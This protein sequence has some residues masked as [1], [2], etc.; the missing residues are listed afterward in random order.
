[1]SFYVAAYDTEAV[2]PWWEKGERS[3]R[4]N[5]FSYTPERIDEFL[6]GVRSVAEAH[7]QRE[8]PASFFLVAK[9]LKLAGPELRSILDH[10]LFDIQCHTFTHPD[11]IGLDED[12]AALRYELVD[13][14]NLIEDTFG[15]PVIGLTAPGGYTHGLTGYPRILEFMWEAGYRYLRSVGTGPNRTMPAPLNQP[16]WY[17]QDG[18]PNLLEIPSHAWHDNILTGQPGVVRWPP[19][20]P[21][22][23]PGEMPDNAQGV[24]EAYAPGIDYC[25]EHDMLYYMPIFHPWSIYRIDKQAG[26]IA[27]LLDHARQKMD[28]AS[29]IH[30]YKHILDNRAL[31]AEELVLD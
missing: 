10:P 25:S 30:I 6:A 31:A 19:A 1:M 16:F 11:L 14:K 26:Q 2:Y 12:E 8:A 27:L 23:Y 3:H 24:Y 21:W 22:G 7:L 28:M 13:A 20:L 4:E 15:R 18:F 5:G 9:L 29:C 17:T